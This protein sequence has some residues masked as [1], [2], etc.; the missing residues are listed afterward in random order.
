MSSARA[1]DDFSSPP[2]AGHRLGEDHDVL[3]KTI[4][5]NR[6][7]AE[8]RGDSCCCSVLTLA[9]STSGARR[10]PRTPGRRRGRRAPRAQKSTM[11]QAADAAEGGHVEF[12]HRRVGRGNSRH[13]RG[14]EGGPI[15]RGMAE[16]SNAL[17]PVRGRHARQVQN[18]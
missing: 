12:E 3:A 15:R 5:R 11:A 8:M 18:L 6:A 16:D 17:R 10:S 13:R 1:G 9:N 14:S 2:A 7:D 4:S